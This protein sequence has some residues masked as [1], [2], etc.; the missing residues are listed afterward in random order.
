MA[1]IRAR[2]ENNN[3]LIYDRQDGWARVCQFKGDVN[4]DDAIDI[5]DVV[6][7]IQWIFSEGPAP[8]PAP[9]SGDVNCD[10]FTDISDCV[11]LIAYIFSGGPAPCGPCYP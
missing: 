4:A 11:Y 8:I 9:L 2:D 3:V 1:P 6:Y 10:D 7:I 5:S